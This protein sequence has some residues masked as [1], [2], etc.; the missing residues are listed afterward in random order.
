MVQCDKVYIMMIMINISDHRLK[1]QDMTFIILC[2][3][4]SPSL[5]QTIYL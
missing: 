4:S 2:L 3:L 1:S 5:D